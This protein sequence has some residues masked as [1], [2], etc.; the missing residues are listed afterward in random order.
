MI[1]SKINGNEKSIAVIL[2]DHKIFG[3][4]FLMTLDKLNLFKSV[5]AFYNEKDFL[6]FV[7]ANQN[8][9]LFLFIDYYLKDHNS[10]E[11]ISTVKKLSREI[12]IIV[13]SSLT[14]P[15]LAKTIFDYEPDG[16]ISKS[17]PVDTIVECVYA[18]NNRKS[19]I[20]SEIKNI[21]R[22]FEESKQIPFTKKELYLLNYFAQGL[23]IDQTADKVFLSRHTIIAHRRKMMEKTNTRSISELLAYCRQLDII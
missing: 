3:D 18:I 11:I 20:C 19:Y 8:D 22:S 4:S 6:H 23:S 10:L 1:V 13:I 2:D 12:K 14:N 9:P 5:K 7:K 15:Q 21:I 17:S 16:F